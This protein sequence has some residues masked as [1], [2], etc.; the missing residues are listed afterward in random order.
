MTFAWAGPSHDDGSPHHH[1]HS[2]RNKMMIESNFG[3]FELTI[4]EMRKTKHKNPT[5]NV[6]VMINH[7]LLNTKT[8]QVIVQKWHL[9]YWR[10]QIPFSG[11]RDANGHH[12]CG[13]EQ[14]RLVGDVIIGL[15]ESVSGQYGASTN[16]CVSLFTWE[17]A[18]PVLREIGY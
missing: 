11:S 5:L 18:V 14:Y 2:S 10:A 6:F 4:R 9:T 8:M 7:N 1:T 13:D 16:E 17:T 3:C 15:S 12:M